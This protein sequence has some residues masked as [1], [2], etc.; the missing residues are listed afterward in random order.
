MRKWRNYGK[1]SLAFGI[2]KHF[3]SK[4]DRIFKKPDFCMKNEKL[5]YIN[6]HDEEKNHKVKNNLRKNEESM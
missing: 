4:N 1:D 6:I 5:I 3:L 2:Y